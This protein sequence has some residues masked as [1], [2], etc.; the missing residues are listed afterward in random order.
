MYLSPIPYALNGVTD[1][2]PGVNGIARNENARCAEAVEQAYAFFAELGPYTDDLGSKQRH[3]KAAGTA[4]KPNPTMAGFGVKL[5]GSTGYFAATGHQLRP[6]SREC[7]FVYGATG[8]Q[9]LSQMHEFPGSGTS[10]R[11]LNVSTSSK[12]TGYIYDGAEK[13]VAGTTTLVVGQ[14]Y[15]AVMTATNSLMSVY[16]DGVFEGSIAIGNAG[17]QGYTTPE[18]V[19]GYN[20]AAA[21]PLSTTNTLFWHIEYNR[22]LSA[23]DVRHRYL[24]QMEMF[25]LVDERMVVGVTAGGGATL[26][27]VEL[28][29][30]VGFETPALLQAHILSAADAAMAV[31]FETPALLSGG[32]LNP[33]G[34]AFGFEFE[35]P[36]LTQAHA[37]FCADAVLAAYFDS[38]NLSQS[39]LFAPVEMNFAVPFDLATLAMIS[40]GAPGFRMRPIGKAGRGEEVRNSSR[41]SDVAATSR[42]K[43]IME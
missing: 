11:G 41:S 26:N 2:I 15:H 34:A 32:V 29:D 3:A 20:S 38:V 12:I 18:L 13:H 36:I 17:H 9:A 23:D 16:L 22:V 25:R 27:P 37:L 39:H 43:T 19:F 33:A 14:V 7:L 21:V 10:D 6:W 1:M 42:S 28:T 35:T 40:Q 24:N 4:W 5:A 8:G 30:S 31:G